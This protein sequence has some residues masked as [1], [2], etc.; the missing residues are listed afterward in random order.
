[1]EDENGQERK[2][3]VD[4]FGRSQEPRE[5]CLQAVSGYCAEVLLSLLV[6]C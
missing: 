3:R 2:L 4:C 5:E 1:M 6:V